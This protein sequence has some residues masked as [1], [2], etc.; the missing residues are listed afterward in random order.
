VAEP[1]KVQQKE[2][3]RVKEQRAARVAEPQKVQQEE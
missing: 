1:Q 3:R 2:L